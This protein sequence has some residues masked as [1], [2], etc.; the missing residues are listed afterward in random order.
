MLK[1]ISMIVQSVS[2]D[3]GHASLSA[4]LRS[5]NHRFLRCFSRLLAFPG[6]HAT[7]RRGVASMFCTL[8][9]SV[10]GQVVLLPT[11]VAAPPS[12]ESALALQPVQKDFSFQKVAAAD[13]EK[14]R[15]LDLTENGWTGWIVESADG[16]RLRRF[17]DTNADKKIDLWCYYDQGV[18]VYRD[19]DS[20]FNGKADQYRWL[21]T[22]GTRWGIDR[23]ENGKVDFWKQISAEEV[24]AEV[25]AALAEGDS[26]RFVRLLATESE[27]RS[28]DLGSSTTDRLMEKA[29]KA[30]ADFAALASKQKGVGSS[31]RWVQFASPSPGIVPEG[32]NGSKSDVRVYENAVAMFDDAGKGGQVLIGT[33]VQVGDAWRLVDLPQ[34]VADDQP[35]AQSPGV[36]FTPGGTMST[37]SATRSGMGAETQELVA[38]LEKIDSQLATASI[39]QDQAELNRRRVDVVEKLIESASTA[40]ERETWMRQLVDTVSVAVQSGVYPGGLERLRKFSADLPAGDKGLESYVQFQIISTEYVSK[41]T[42]DADF[43]KVQ[44]WYLTSLNKFVES[45]PASPEAAQAMLQLALS[46]EFEERETEALEYYNKVAKS[47]PGTDM[48]EKAAGAVRRLESLGKPIAFTGRTV[49]GEPF[50]LARLKGRP[51]VIHYWA[52]WCEA[53]KQDMKLLRQ[54]QAKYQTVGLQIVGVNV[55]GSRNTAAQFLQD[56][57][58]PWIHLFEDGGLESSGLAKQLGVQTLPM[59]MLLNADGT[60]ASNNIYAA[61]LDTELAKIARAMTPPPSA[62]PANRPPAARPAPARPTAGVPSTNRPG[63]PTRP[64]G[65][66]PGSK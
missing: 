59:M 7:A 4:A 42:P 63:V 25:I 5:S 48:G 13:V 47:F 3:H 23:D 65:N 37:A 52:T 56:N 12:A 16:T 43:A 32:T 30:T 53:C 61:S 55:D 38:A 20:D 45:F 22:A 44:E 62:T 14:C 1:G 57:S 17:A 50:D 66:R 54:L 27:I 18:E 41:Q 46:K 39:P 9:I 51:V 33:I 31:A 24:S 40:T 64:A 21:G 29:K 8:A 60:V 2:P 49:K 58:A 11:A 28:L 36:F 15:V 34:V 10:V 26:E 6:R 19:V 35:L